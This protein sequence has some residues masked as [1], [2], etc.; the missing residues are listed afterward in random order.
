MTS[1]PL[2]AP[3]ATWDG[4]AYRAA[5]GQQRS[6]GMRL[7]DLLAP[8]PGETILDVGCGDG[9]LTAEIARRVGPGGRVVGLD[10]SHSMIETARAAAP[11]NASFVLRRAEDLDDVEQY[12][13]VFSN[14]ALHWV[15]DQEG[16]TAR[17][18]RALRPGG[19]FVA[20]FGGDGNCREFFT[21]A[22]CVALTEFNAYHAESPKTLANR[23]PTAREFSAALR[24]AGFR[25]HRVL[26]RPRPARFGSREAAEAW[27]ASTNH[28]YFAPLPLELRPQFMRRVFDAYGA[29]ANI[30]PG[31]WTIRFVRVIAAAWK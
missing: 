5:S 25:R 17:I 7:I 15:L 9:M 6:W 29:R 22:D 19:R 26:L 31:R 4:Q 3:A 8:L 21:T 2:S 13:A 23:F 30:R 28:G 10:A 24:A 11:A 16:V 14:A 18:Y 20:E 27:F 1:P 12:D